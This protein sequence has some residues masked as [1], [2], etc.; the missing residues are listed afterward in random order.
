MQKKKTT[1]P[2]NAGK[3]AKGGGKGGKDLGKGVLSKNFLLGTENSPGASKRKKKTGFVR[4]NWPQKVSSRCKER[5]KKKKGFFSQQ[6]EMGEKKKPKQSGKVKKSGKWGAAKKGKVTQ[7]EKIRFFLG[8]LG[9]G[10]MVR[11]GPEKDQFNEIGPFKKKKKVVGLVW[12][13]Q[14]RHKRHRVCLTQ[15][16]G[17]YQGPLGRHGCHHKINLTRIN[18][19]E[20]RGHPL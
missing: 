4:K 8:G 3:K 20:D 9:G 5:Q 11:G 6:P 15:K 18:I 13:F 2:P 10:T 1:L 16:P 7:K 17:E 12:V 19:S 14:Q